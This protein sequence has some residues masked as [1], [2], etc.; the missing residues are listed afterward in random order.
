MECLERIIIATPKH[1]LPLEALSSRE[2]G[3]VFLTILQA[4]SAIASDPL[5]RVVR[6]DPGELGTEW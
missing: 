2:R 3:F 5:R 4:F 6:L 1:E